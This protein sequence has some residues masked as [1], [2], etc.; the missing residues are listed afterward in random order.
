MKTVAAAAGPLLLL[1]AAGIS[2]I[3]GGAAADAID[4]RASQLMPWVAQQTGY[5]AEHVKVTV[6]FVEPRT[7]SLIAYSVSQSDD[8]T[9]EAIAAGSTIFLPRWFELGKN[10]DILVHELTHVLQYAND[11]KFRCRA[12]QERQAYEAQAAFVAATGIGRKPDPF[13]V[14]MLHCTAYPVRYPRALS[15]SR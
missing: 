11:A 9:P 12:E 6:L 10:D 5:S 14:F 3:S 13:A 15:M 4:E 7:I 2:L 8:P 1:A